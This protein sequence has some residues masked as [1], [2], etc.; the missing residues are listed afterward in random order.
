[1]WKLLENSKWARRAVLVEGIG[2]FGDMVWAALSSLV[3]KIVG[4]LAVTSAIAALVEGY[5]FVG[6]VAVA[7]GIATATVFLFLGLVALWLIRR[8][9]K[10]LPAQT[11]PVIEPPTPQSPPTDGGDVAEFRGTVSDPP[12]FDPKGLY[13]SRMIVSTGEFEERRVLEVTAVCFNATQRSIY[14]QRIEGELK[15]SESKAGSSREIGTLPAPWLIEGEGRPKTKKIAHGEE[16]TISFQQRVPQDFAEKFANLNTDNKLSLDCDSL[17]VVMASH[18]GDDTARLPVWDGIMLWRDPAMIFAGRIIKATMEPI[19]C[20]RASLP[21]N[22]QRSSMSSI[23]VSSPTACPSFSAAPR[24]TSARR[25]SR[26][27]AGG[28]PGT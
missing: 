13:V 14:V 24:T 2:S 22:T 3:G 17:N 23:P 10:A 9:G 28:M 8:S 26:W 1:M 19:R 20:S 21:S 16:F 12:P 18:F 7:L 25:C 4:G 11:Q 6:A 5:G 27:A 15:I